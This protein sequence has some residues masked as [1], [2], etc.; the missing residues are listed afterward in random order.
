M[1]KPWGLGS[2]AASRSTKDLAPPLLG[3]I[4]KFPGHRAEVPR[5]SGTQVRGLDKEE[6]ESSKWLI[7]TGRRASE[8]EARL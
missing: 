2:P 7:Y 1:A 5:R 6:A 4:P 3:P 8:S